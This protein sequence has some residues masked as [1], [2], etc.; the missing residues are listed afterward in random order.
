MKVVIDTNIFISAAMSSSGAARQVIRMCLL[1]QC[2][3][4]MGNALF[5]EYEDVCARDHLFE[6]KF[7]SW[8]ERE[9]LLNAFIASCIWVPIYFLWRPNLRDEADNHL[10]E[11]AIASNAQVIVTANKRDFTNSELKFSNLEI[12][13]AAEFLKKGRH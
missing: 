3:S 10:M 9:S 4:L 6:D 5:G 8:S 11:L 1:G 12:L 7:I 2:Q 13:D